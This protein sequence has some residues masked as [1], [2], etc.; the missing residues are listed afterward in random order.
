MAL[1]LTINIAYRFDND[2]LQ[3]EAIADEQTKQQIKQVIQTAKFSNQEK[4]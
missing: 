1:V 3:L 2:L 4:D